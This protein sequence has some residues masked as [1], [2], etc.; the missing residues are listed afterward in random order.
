MSGTGYNLKSLVSKHSIQVPD[1]KIIVSKYIQGHR[2]IDDCESESMR[3]WETK[4]RECDI[5]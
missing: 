4:I 2:A 3:D 5:T 1:P